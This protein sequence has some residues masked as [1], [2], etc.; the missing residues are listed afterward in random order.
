MTGSGSGA[1]PGNTG[2]LRACLLVV[3]IAAAAAG[4]SSGPPVPDWQLEAQASLQRATQAY[5]AGDARIAAVEFERAR[6]ELARTGRADRVAIAELTR[7][8][9]QVASLELLDTAASGRPACPAFEPLRADAGEAAAAYADL[10]RAPLAAARIGQLPVTQQA[11]AA[12]G[13]DAA[14]REAAVRAIADPLSRL[15]AAA[16]AL[17]DGVAPPGLIAEAVD[18]ASAQGWRRPLLAWLTVQLRRAEAAGDSG[19][20]QALQR[21]IE[22]VGS[23]G[24]AG[25]AGVGR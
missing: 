17:R 2:R 23:A 19:A 11:A 7:C 13:D 8:A 10:L 9:T 4:C 14:R 21:R 25:S 12:A 3:A 20:A 15:V 5:L 16:L 22:L 18:T 6:R 1:F 24:P